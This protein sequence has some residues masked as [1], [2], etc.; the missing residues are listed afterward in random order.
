MSDLLLPASCS[1]ATAN[2]PTI[3]VTRDI[4]NCIVIIGC[5]HITH[6]T[7]APITTTLQIYHIINTQIYACQI[8]HTTQIYRIC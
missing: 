3:V 4:V 6:T 2:G 1:S 8:H 5:G 7:I